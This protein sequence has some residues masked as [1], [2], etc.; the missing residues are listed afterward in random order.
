MKK[1]FKKVRGYRV[2]LLVPDVATSKIHMTED[3]K[4]SVIEAKLED[5]KKLKVYAVGEAVSESDVKEGDEVML[6]D[7]VLINSRPVSIDKDTN[8]II[9]NVND[10][11]H[12]W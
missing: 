12:I 7:R 11:H 8:V 1:P 2:Y 9:A 10:I 6:D 3:V 5:F 4:R